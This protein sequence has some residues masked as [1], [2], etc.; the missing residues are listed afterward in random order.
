M[1]IRLLAKNKPENR[2]KI[3]RAGAIGPLISLISSTDLQ[4]Q[5]YGVTAILNLSLYDKNKELIADYGAIK[6]LVTALRTGTATSKEN[7]ACALLRLSQIEQSNI[8]I[9]R[10]GAIPLLV[11]LLESG[12]CRGKKDASTALYSLCSA[13]EN[14]LRAIKAGIIRPLIELMADF[15]SSMID[16]LASVLSLLLSVEEARAAAVEEGVIPD[17]SLGHS[18]FPSFLYS[19]SS[20]PSKAAAD[21][22]DQING[23]SSVLASSLLAQSTK[24]FIRTSVM[25]SLKTVGVGWHQQFGRAHLRNAPL[26]HGISS[27]RGIGPLIGPSTIVKKSLLL[28]ISNPRVL[29]CMWPLILLNAFSEPSSHGLSVRYLF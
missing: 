22:Q 27:T 9:G 29:V 3:A 25:W 26:F 10:S 24:S 11:K 28:S 19:A 18:L 15:G 13:K 17:Q 12:G 8:A 2:I 21:S 1:E 4:L 6:P 16:K 14:K 5:E 23:R 7:A 20:S